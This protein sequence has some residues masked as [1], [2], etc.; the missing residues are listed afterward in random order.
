MQSLKDPSI[1][2]DWQSGVI[3]GANWRERAGLALLRLAAVAT[4]SPERPGFSKLAAG[5]SALFPSEKFVRVHFA[6]DTVYQFPYGDAYWSVL[7]APG[8]RYE[9]EIDGFVRRCAQENISYVFLD[10]GANYGYWSCRTSAREAGGQRAIAIEAS[11]ES[12]GHAMRNRALNDNRFDA[13]HRAISREND[14]TVQLFGD[15]K[16]E[17]RSL[18]PSSAGDSATESVRSINLDHL[19]GIDFKSEK[20]VLKLDLEGMEVAALEGGN[21]WLDGETLVIF[22]DHGSDRQHQT[23]RAMRELFGLR[24]FA[25][26]TSG[27]FTEILDLSQLDKLK[28]VRRKGYD[29]F[30]SASPFWI[31]FMAG[32]RSG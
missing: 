22:E 14:L 21:N 18:M 11:S 7:C 12:Y 23:A 13:H 1:D 4:R 10:C 2:L 28:K 31:E 29:F 25:G 8:F 19:Q 27:E 26:S 5:I 20:T 16:H 24:I 6:D 3:D 15:H 9:P 32:R 30:A 17:Q